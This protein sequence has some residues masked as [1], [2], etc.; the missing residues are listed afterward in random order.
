MHQSHFLYL[1]VVANIRLISCWSQDDL[2]YRY[3]SA[4]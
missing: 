1:V 4:R 2:P 3:R